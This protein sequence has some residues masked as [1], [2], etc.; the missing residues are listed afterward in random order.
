MIN[1]HHLVPQLFIIDFLIETK[2]LYFSLWVV[3][4]VF[5]LCLF[6]LASLARD[7]FMVQVPWVAS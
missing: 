6:L 4:W 5:T 3:A 1:Y 2:L 7:W